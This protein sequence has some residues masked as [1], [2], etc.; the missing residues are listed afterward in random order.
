MCSAMTA[1][2]DLVLLTALFGLIMGVVM[3]IIPFLFAPKKPNPVKST[4]FECG[5]VPVGEGKVRLMM[6]YYAYLLMFVVFDVMLMFLFAWAVIFTS[7][8]LYGAL[9]ITVFMVILMVAL[10]YGLHL[11]KKGELW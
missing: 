6:Q 4:V 8:G 1:G 3:L 9:T 7:I 11:A 5:Q 10:G 2:F